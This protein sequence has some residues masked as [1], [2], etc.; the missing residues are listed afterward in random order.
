MGEDFIVQALSGAI[1]SSP[2][3]LVLIWRLRV[4]DRRVESLETRVDS[5]IGDHTKFMQELLANNK[6]D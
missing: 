1:G 6:E 2:V 3:A 4:A 5:L